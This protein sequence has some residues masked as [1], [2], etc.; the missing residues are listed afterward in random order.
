M[1]HNSDK[2]TTDD[3]LSTLSG[4]TAEPT[5]M[6]GG[7]IV[8]E[9]LT[10][11]EGK[12]LI[13]NGT[14]IKSEKQRS[15]NVG[16]NACLRLNDCEVELKA[17]YSNGSSTMYL[18]SG[19]EAYISGGSLSLY[20]RLSVAYTA[21][22]NITGTYLS[23]VEGNGDVGSIA[24]DTGSVPYV[25]GGRFYLYAQGDVTLRDLEVAPNALIQCAEIEIASNVSGSQDA[26]FTAEN[27][28]FGA[29]TYIAVTDRHTFTLRD[30]TFKAG[31]KKSTLY[32]VR[33]DFK[34]GGDYTKIITGC[35]LSE[36]NVVFDTIGDS[37]DVI[38]LSGNYWGE[39]YDTV[40]KVIPLIKGYDAAHIIINSVLD[41]D[42]IAPRV[43]LNC[44]SLNKV[45]DKLGY[46]TLSWSA[47]EGA[48][49]SLSVD[50]TTVYEG[51]D[52][53]FTVPVG[54]G[55]HTYTVTATDSYDNYRL[56][57]DSFRYDADKESIAADK[58]VP[59]FLVNS[60]ELTG[61]GSLA[62]AVEHANAYS[63]A[64]RIEF[65]SAFAGQS[66]AIGSL[67]S[68][69]NDEALLVPPVGMSF[70]IGKT[71]S[72][73]N[74]VTT[75]GEALNLYDSSSTTGG[76]TVSI[77]S[78]IYDTPVTLREVNISL[79]SS[80][81]N[82]AVTFIGDTTMYGGSISGADVIVS[83]ELTGNGVAIN[84][85]RIQ[86]GIRVKE[87]ACLRLNDCEVELTTTFFNGS[88]SLVLD[89][90][91]EAYITGG[92]L[93][94]FSRLSVAYTATLNISGTYLNGVAGNGSSVV[95]I[96]SGDTGSVPYVDGGRFYLYAQG[97]VT[98][99][100]L[101][102]A[103][104]A[105]IQCAEIEIASN[106]SG[107][108]DAAFT[109]ENVTFGAGSYIAVTDRHTFTLRDCTFKAGNKKSTLY[110]VRRDFKTGGDYT[111][112]ITGCNLSA[113]DIVFSSIGESSDVIDLSGNYWGEGYDTVEK[114]IPLIKGYDAA[115]IIINSVL[116]TDPF[117]PG[118][119][120][121][122]PTLQ[123]ESDG[124]TRVTL[125][126]VGA[127][128]E[129]YT[130]IV[131]GESYR[132]T[133]TSYTLIL[134]DGTH[135]YSV[136]AV[137]SDGNSATA[138][139]APFTLDATAPALTLSEPS[140]RKLGD[141]QT[142]VTLSWACEQGATC[143]LTID[144]GEPIELEGN[145]Y[146][147]ILADGE[148]R[149]SITATDAAGNSTTV[150]GKPFT[151]DGDVTEFALL[152]PKREPM[153]AG[154]TEV[155]ISWTGDK[156]S[157]YTLKLAGKTIKASLIRYDDSTDTYSYTAIL[158]D[159][160]HE[161]SV[162]TTDADGRTEEQASTLLLDTTAP[163]LTLKKPKLSKVAE[164]RVKATLSWSGEAGVLYTVTLQGEAEPVY[165]GYDSQCIIELPLDAAGKR[166]T[167]TVT[168]AAGNTSTSALTHK[169]ASLSYDAVSPE[170]M[171]VNTSITKRSKGKATVQF[172]W[173]GRDDVT[174]KGL[175]YTLVVDGKKLYSGTAATRNISLAD[176]EHSYSVIVTDK[177]GN[178][179]EEKTG[180]ITI[181][182]TAPVLTVAVPQLSYGT[183]EGTGEVTLSWSSD[184]ADATYTLT[185][186]GRVV[187]KGKDKS[188]TLSLADGKH[189]YAVT[190]SDALG[191]TSSAKKG[192]F[193]VSSADTTAPLAVALKPVTT[194][195]Y[196]D[197]LVKATIKWTP[198]AGEKG[199]TYTLM[200]DGEVVSI[201]S[202]ASRTLTLADGKHSY[203]VIATDKAGNSSTAATG[204]FE[205]A[206]VTAPE[207]T[208]LT[209][210]VNKGSLGSN[211]SSATLTWSCGE[212]P[213][214][215]TLK[216]DGKAVNARLV[217]EGSYSYSMDALKDGKHT[218]SLT[219]VDATGNKASYSGSFVT[220]TKAPKVTLGKPRLSEGAGGTVDATLSWKGEKGATYTLTVDGRAV[221]LSDPSA[222]SHLLRG[223]SDGEHSYSVIAT[224]AAGNESKAATGSFFYDT[225]AP[226]I[227]LN[228]ITGTATTSKGITR[229]TATLSWAGE[230]GV[231]YTVKVD[232]KKLS[233]RKLTV[234]KQ[235][236]STLSATT[237]KLT[238]GEHSYS[239]I[240]KDK[241]GNVS[242][243][244]GV[245]SCDGSGAVTMEGLSPTVIPEGTQRLEWSSWDSEG[246]GSDETPTGAS[247]GYSFELTQARQLEV[248]LSGL[249]EDATVLLQ[250]EGAYES[251]TLRANA[252]ATLD[253]EL[254]LSAGTYYLQVLGAEGTGALAS[255]YTLDL[256]LEKNGS[257]QPLQQAY[258]A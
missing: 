174:T 36:V 178:V 251:V 35:N 136:T 12:E 172:S 192:S 96:I 219:V 234:N 195:K 68:L 93:T 50:G 170:L 57:T 61:E 79:E 239:I 220:D 16:T 100:D 152:A 242:T 60:T 77:G 143:K 213:A 5:I 162:T 153:S 105:L 67:L 54:D 240:A 154:K 97:D 159:G 13:A 14:T 19:A 40:E 210:T 65:S 130:L 258:L 237:G 131:D 118:V 121:E 18:D 98:L 75:S 230:D 164:G 173:S 17:P 187:Y 49:Y 171:S 51:T 55:E 144:G 38:D 99:R 222:T 167:V 46:I 147:F 91:A 204:S 201:G 42:P 129:S 214:K 235:T 94:L 59:S 101:E 177:A 29:G 71:F 169:Y 246:F 125:S 22:L 249:A 104:N 87:N 198:P 106:V 37:T 126:W 243:Y 241:A 161:Y 20:S 26:A 43:E 78:T 165:V 231:S 81:D 205:S 89:G 112:I 188:Y 245:F 4:T 206:D 155:T 248:K 6:N 252:G 119:Q 82:D 183:N 250:K 1:S 7:S 11:N 122:A 39:G 114:V 15:I 21:T 44:P 10:V 256:E 168:D 216:V 181:D 95:G 74:S 108:K 229:T 117:A 160:S 156:D 110:I 32:I 24:G 209:H 52:T 85:T 244:S 102:V 236:V 73:T 41:S 227:I 221:E 197:G 148:H 63:G 202:S 182:A 225:T 215:L 23:G 64:C 123:K 2:T 247:K 199:L 69:V 84:S 217:S 166:Y 128:A 150:E 90:G 48:T 92:S 238:A 70:A 66:L 76:T 145:T 176:G 142:R 232:G 25:D 132:T 116:E 224:D 163:K 58:P 228:A 83:G 34:T 149:Y 107:A 62:R 28:T 184:D 9:N 111:K 207:V 115:H 8:D 194:K 135:S 255:S 27:V 45:Q 53:Q 31:D 179:S 218:Y 139:G 133:E 190:A 200:V 191:N 233:V 3:E 211:S 103:P 180:T 137:A 72:I 146:S 189:S 30:C 86:D 193:S 223:L 186:D 88:N 33:R 208:G 138:E 212:L 141:G 185:L 158:K 254:S 151:T 80:S 157:P 175:R 253:R 226:D 257:K 196:K 47:V 127:N 113:V 140:L 109:A 56:H 203:S 134:D 120:L 124:K